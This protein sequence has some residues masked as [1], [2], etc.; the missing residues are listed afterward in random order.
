MP[1]AGCRILD[2]GYRMRDENSSKLKGER[3]KVKGKNAGAFSQLLNFYSFKPSSFL[4]S[5]PPNFP[6]SSL[7]GFLASQPPS[8]FTSSQ[9]RMPKAECPCLM[10]SVR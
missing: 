5:Q 7:T 6:A 2:A 3:I 10:P 1:G 4:A 9:R 8:F